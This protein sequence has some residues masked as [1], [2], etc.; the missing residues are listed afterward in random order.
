MKYVAIVLLLF[1]VSGCGIA[2]HEGHIETF[3]AKGDRTGLYVA[4][5]DTRMSMEVI[6]PNGVTVKVDSRHDS[7]LGLILK[8]AFEFATLG[9][10]VD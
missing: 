3:N 2:R 9:L 6:D 4:T 7:T 1:C 8:G 10:L 5:L